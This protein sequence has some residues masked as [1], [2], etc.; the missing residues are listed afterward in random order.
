MFS[1]ISAV[2]LFVRDLE[3]CSAFY[4]DKIGL[5]VVF[6]D[7]EST[8]FKLDGQDFALVAINNAAGMVKVDIA[9]FMSADG[10]AHPVMLCADTDNADAVYEALRANG[11]AFTQPPVDQHWG[12]RAAYFRDPEGNFWEIR[13]PI[14]RPA[15]P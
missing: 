8:A 2:V 10:K 5:E 13:Q 1:R 7:A 4:R 9:E 15:Q 12:Y 3:T 6:R 11:V 14:P